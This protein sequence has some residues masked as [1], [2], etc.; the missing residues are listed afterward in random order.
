[1]SVPSVSV[2][3]ERARYV[4]RF[5]LVPRLLLLLPL[6]W[7]YAVGRT[8]GRFRYR[9]H[10]GLTRPHAAEM[11]ARLGA[12]PQQVE[13]WLERCF[14]LGVGEDLDW[15]LFNRMEKK[16]PAAVIEV[17]GREQLDEALAHGR[18]AMLC[19][20]HF[21]GLFT[22]MA[23]LSVL[24]YPVN[25]VGF[26]HD[27]LKEGGDRWYPDRRHAVLERL[28]CRLLKQVPG[29]GAAERAISAL[30]ANEI[31]LTAID[32]TSVKRTVEVPFLGAPGF[33]PSGPAW[34]AQRAGAPLVFFQIRRTERWVPAVLEIWPPFWVADDVEAAVRRLAASLEAAILADPPSWGPWLYPRKFV[35]SPPSHP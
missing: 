5:T 13:R 26:F 8:L 22:S 18:G 14:E 23:A 27:T 35:W 24:G 2:L 28:G 21:F 34:L 10:R 31:V 29:G 1:M 9:R 30:N 6:P 33:F 19:S 11:R 25:V 4:Y 7:A 16:G 20:G 32:H 12:P 3:R 17:V 15:P